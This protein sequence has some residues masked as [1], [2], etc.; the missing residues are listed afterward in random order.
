[1]K[2]LRLLIAAP[3]IFFAAGVDAA[4]PWLPLH[5]ASVS[6]GPGAHALGALALAVLGVVLLS[7]RRR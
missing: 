2:T 1:M 6:F 7:P 5:A 3:F 4:M